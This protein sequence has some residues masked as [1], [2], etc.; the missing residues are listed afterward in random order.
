M[1]ELLRLI[2]VLA[3][4]GG[5]IPAPGPCFGQSPAPEAQLL[6]AEALVP[7]GPGDVVS[8]I[9]FPVAEYSREVTVQPDGKIE[10]PLIGALEIKGMNSQEVKALLET[11]Y[12][13]FVANP[14]ITV[15]VRR[16]MGRRVAIIGQIGTP[17]YYEFRDG[18]KILELVSLAGGVR[19]LG[20]PSKTVILRQTGSKPEVLNVNLAAVLRGEFDRNIELLP[21]DTIHIPKAGYTRS[22][23]W[24]TVNILP[25]LSLA[26]LAATLMLVAR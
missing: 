4:V 17:G 6:E 11:R 25:W 2:V 15:N 18:M 16:F 20:K 24:M 5:S 22:A 14:K 13:K 8:I 19:D 26:G 23:E 10:L 1:K 3:L 21:G 12:A 7:V 9:V